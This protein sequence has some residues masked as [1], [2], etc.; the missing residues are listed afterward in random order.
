MA[1]SDPV[2]QDTT[3]TE[4]EGRSAMALEKSTTNGNPENILHVF[5]FPPRE[6]LPDKTPWAPA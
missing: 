2:T 1:T 5:V 6:G 4:P 3:G